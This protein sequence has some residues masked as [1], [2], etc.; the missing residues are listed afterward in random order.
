M[1]ASRSVFVCSSAYGTDWAG[2]RYVRHVVL[3]D[4]EEYAC[5]AHQLTLL[6]QGELPADLDLCPVPHDAG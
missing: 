6:R 2:L 1:E 3:L 4:G 5:D